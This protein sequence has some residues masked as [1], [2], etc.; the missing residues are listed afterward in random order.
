MKKKLKSRRGFTLIEMVLVI[1]I[2]V[3]LAAV[4]IFGI[5]NYMN[6]AE[7][8][9]ASLSIHNSGVN[10]VNEAIGDVIGH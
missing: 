2:I 4:L 1:A 9:A 10:Q 5:G 3:I 8:A 6:K 7:N